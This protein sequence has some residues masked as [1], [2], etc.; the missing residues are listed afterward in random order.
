[1]NRNIIRPGR[2]PTER[3]LFNR[4]TVG[5]SRFPWQKRTGMAMLSD[6]KTEKAGTRYGWKGTPGMGRFGGGWN[7]CLGFRLGGKTIYIELLIG[8]IRI[9]WYPPKP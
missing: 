6:P 5:A 7:W 2:Y 9:S 4:I 3:I 8:A 1:M